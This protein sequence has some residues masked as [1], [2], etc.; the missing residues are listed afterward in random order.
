AN[1]VVLITLKKGSPGTN[2]INVRSTFGISHVRN[3]LNLMSAHEF[4]LQAN[5][6]AKQLGLP[7]YYTDKQITSF[8]KGTD[9]Q[10]VVFRRAVKQ[11]TNLSFSGGTEKTQYYINGS[12]LNDQGIVKHS[13][14]KRYG[15]TTR[16]GSNPLKG[17]TVGGSAMFTATVKNRKRTN[18]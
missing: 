12:Y 5:E 16:I 6:R 3:K 11:S 1:G 8:G 10:D 14:F 13:S 7:P 4:A 2:K 9:W 18:T 17:L 15:F